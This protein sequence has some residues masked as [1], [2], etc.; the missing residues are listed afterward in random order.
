VTDTPRRTVIHVGNRMDSPGG[1]A[2][3]MRYL[4]DSALGE[5]WNLVFVESVTGGAS[6]PL[7]V[8]QSAVFPFRVAVALLRWP[9]AIVHVHMT[10]RGSF[11]RK[12]I[13]I[14]LARLARRD[15]IVH[16]HGA[17]HTWARQRPRSMRAVTRLFER[18]TVVVALSESLRR[19]ILEIAPGTCCI[20][21]RNGVPIPGQPATGSTPPR[22]LF[23]GLLHPK[24]G[25]VELF[26]AIRELQSEDVPATWF[27]AGGGDA[28]QARDLADALPRPD[29][30]E[31]SGWIGA[32]RKDAELRA[33][34][35]FVLPSYD[36]G[37]PLALLEAMSY[38]L[39]CVATPVGGI[40]E[41]L[42]D[43]TNGL[44]VTSADVTS[45]ASGLRRVLLQSD[46]RRALGEAARRDVSRRYSADEVVARWSRL[47][48]DV[49]AER[50]IVPAEWKG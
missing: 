48:E 27:F 9:G 13:A 10:G 11:W 5:R 50:P 23:L 24:K 30:V 47:Y 4:R 8:V 46:L 18:V 29:L 39:A 36:E 20:V 31:I 21:I 19:H 44:L 2:A 37:L 22:V 49:F 7:R 45:L 43:E 34:D 15:V 32:Q 33:A 14:G 35:V 3:V 40:P 26:D 17:I 28:A 38:G 42:E 12:R 1:I 25:I 16:V 41:V 6:L